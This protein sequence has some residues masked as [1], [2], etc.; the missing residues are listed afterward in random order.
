MTAGSSANAQVMRTKK[1]PVSYRGEAIVSIMCLSPA[2][3]KHTEELLQKE[4]T[5]ARRGAGLS[6]EPRQ[7]D[8]K[9]RTCGCIGRAVGQMFTE[10]KRGQASHSTEWEQ[11]AS[12]PRLHP[13]HGWQFLTICKAAEGYYSARGNLVSTGAKM[14]LYCV[15]IKPLEMRITRR[16]LSW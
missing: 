12:L 10:R 5:L 2:V 13:C 15:M 7:G 9:S 4:R 6:E 16:G 3:R 11:H 14:A 1:D 8:N